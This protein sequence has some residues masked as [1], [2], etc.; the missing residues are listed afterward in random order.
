MDKNIS[1]R[2]I[3]WIRKALLMRKPSGVEIRGSLY[4]LQAE[5]SLSNF[6]F[7]DVIGEIYQRKPVFF[8]LS[9]YPKIRH[10]FGKVFGN[11]GLQVM[12][13]YILEKFCLKKGEQ[14]IHEFKG[15]IKKKIPQ[16]YMAKVVN[17][18]IYVTNRRIIAQGSLVFES[19]QSTG[20]AKFGYIFGSKP[21]YGYL[22][23]IK[24]LYKLTPLSGSKNRKLSYFGLRKSKI[25]INV[26]KKEITLDKLHAFLNDFQTQKPLE[27]KKEKVEY[28][29]VVHQK[30]ERKIGN[31][32]IKQV[33]PIE[34]KEEVKK[35]RVIYK[36]VV[37][38]KVERGTVSRFDC[39]TAW[40]CCI[41]PIMVIIILIVF[42]SRAQG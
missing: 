38:Q 30:A 22:F 35:E 9:I 10:K 27:H 39:G 5:N 1:N 6:E 20:E 15:T 2:Y 13:K 16:K 19:H 42:F 37:Y 29:P 4:A 33:K 24:N 34:H 40:I 21:C 32:F 28:E 14:I 41:T 7:F 23:P 18:T 25:T 8:M 17:G 31:L 26:P 36:P 12:D 11:E 3:I